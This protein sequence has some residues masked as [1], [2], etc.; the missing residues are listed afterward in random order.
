MANTSKGSQ[1]IPQ[2]DTMTKKKA[3]TPDELYEA[4]KELK[5]A[6]E[7]ITAAKLR[8]DTANKHFDSLCIKASEKTTKSFLVRYPIT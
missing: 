2:E 5:E 4:W 1:N 6:T 8:F 3:V 7:S